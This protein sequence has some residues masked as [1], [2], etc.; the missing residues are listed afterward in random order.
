MKNS[1]KIALENRFKWN[2]V[3]CP[4]VDS[5]NGTYLDQGISYMVCIY[6]KEVGALT[7]KADIIVSQ[8]EP[9]TFQSHHSNNLNFTH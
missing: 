8:W 2:Y 5:P 3:F 6:H 9:L 4:K 7:I 1:L